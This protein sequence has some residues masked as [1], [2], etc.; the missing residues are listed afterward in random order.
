MEGDSARSDS[1]EDADLSRDSRDSG[2]RERARHD[3]AGGSENP[4]ELLAAALESDDVT[5]SEL[6]A[7]DRALDGMMLGED[8]PRT[9]M[10]GG[11][12]LISIEDAEA[13][14]SPR[15]LKVLAE[16]FKGKLTQTRH[17]DEKDQI[18]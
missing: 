12:D 14:L 7:V 9:G 11:N 16:K 2:A 1:E 17:L 5:D 15:V 18:F 8:P 4:A 3:D 10:G 13:K 6:E